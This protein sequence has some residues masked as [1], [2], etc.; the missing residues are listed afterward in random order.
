MRTERLYTKNFKAGS[1][2]ITSSVA[3]DIAVYDLTKTPAE[4]AIPATMLADL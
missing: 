1:D 3:S 2:D 4:N